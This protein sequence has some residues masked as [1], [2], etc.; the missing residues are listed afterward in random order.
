MDFGWVVE[1]DLVEEV[2]LVVEEG[3]VEEVGLVVEE[4]LVVVCQEGAVHPEA[5]KGHRA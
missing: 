1:E 4:G 5:G 2:G 3:L